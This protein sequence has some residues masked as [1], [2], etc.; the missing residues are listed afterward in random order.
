MYAIY[1][2]KC[3]KKGEV[4]N[5]VKELEKDYK[6][7][8]DDPNTELFLRRALFELLLIQ[9]HTTCIDLPLFILMCVNII[10]RVEI[11]FGFMCK[12]II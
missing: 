5:M 1:L 6:K 8:K 4:M 3:G 9:V 7:S 11:Y 12:N 10:W 2:R